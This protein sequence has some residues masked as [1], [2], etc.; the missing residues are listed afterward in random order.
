MLKIFGKTKDEP[1]LAPL[2]QE[3]KK[4]VP[5]EPF[6]KQKLCDRI[7]DYMKSEEKRKT[8][9]KETRKNRIVRLSKEFLQKWDEFCD[10][11]GDDISGFFEIEERL[12]KAKLLTVTSSIDID[13]GNLLFFLCTEKTN[14]EHF[15]KMKIFLKEDGTYSMRITPYGMNCNKT[16]NVY[17][18]RNTNISCYN[19][20]EDA[21]KYFADTKYLC[22]K[23]DNEDALPCCEAFVK[24]V[25]FLEKDLDSIKKGIGNAVRERTKR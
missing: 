1:S 3:V 13:T 4:T 22:E 17:F 20:N 15:Q 18:N 10:R 6:D 16:C 23:H 19:V 25:T 9:E 12:V 21:R 5:E 2:P 7:D 11:H 8:D 24:I 14:G